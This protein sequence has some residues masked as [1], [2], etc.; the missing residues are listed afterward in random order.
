[1]GIPTQEWLCQQIVAKTQEAIIFTDRAGIIQLW[2]MGAEIIFGYQAAEVIGKS[3]DFIIPE[4]LRDRHWEG[5]H[6]VM[7]TGVTQYDRQLLAVPAIRKDGAR[8]SLEFTIV[9]I[10]DSQDE[11]L[12]AAALLRDVTVRWQQERELRARLAA[13]EGSHQPGPTN[14]P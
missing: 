9:L 2:N 7:A 13:L 3:L 10:R 1:M 8:I 6:R 12:G 11:V 4:R 14:A 5:Y